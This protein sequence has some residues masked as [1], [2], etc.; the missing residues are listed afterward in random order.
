[1]AQL[2]SLGW[3]PV[4][5]AGDSRGSRQEEM[6]GDGRGAGEERQTL[7]CPLGT[8]YHFRGPLAALTL[9]LVL[10]LTSTRPTVGLGSEA[11]F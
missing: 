7:H 9:S 2:L 5:Q 3:S 4:S 8:R 11:L 6:V 10:T 1:M